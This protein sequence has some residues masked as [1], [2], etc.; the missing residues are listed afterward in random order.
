MS[1]EFCGV[2]DMISAIGWHQQA[3][4]IFD[5]SKHRQCMKIS[6]VSKS[7]VPYDL[8]LQNLQLPA[9]TVIFR[10]GQEIPKN[11]GENICTG[12]DQQ[13]NKDSETVKKEIE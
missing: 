12:L 4:S 6:W 3:K 5:V 7:I 10:N 2:A 11:I 13:N 9:Y 8:I 1:R